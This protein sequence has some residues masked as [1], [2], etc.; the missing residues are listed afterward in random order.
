M[1]AGLSGHR[2]G[3]GQIKLPLDVVI[4][5]G[6]ENRQRLAPSQG[7]QAGIAKGQRPL[8]GGR[9]FVLADRQKR[10]LCITDEPTVAGRV[11]CLEAKG[12]DGISAGERLAEMPQRGGLDER[13]IGEQDEDVVMAFRHGL[14]CGEDRMSGP[15]PLGLKMNRDTRKAPPRLCSHILPVWTDHDGDVVDLRLAHRPEHMRK[16]AAPGDPVQHLRH[17]GLHARAFARRENDGECPARF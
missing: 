17:G 15:V 2:H 5:D 1:K 6:L 4:A 7:H 9:I 11:L 10:A 16:Q 8:R 13:R 3:I 14:A 12:N